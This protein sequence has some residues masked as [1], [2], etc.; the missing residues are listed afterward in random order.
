[1]L[2]SCESA[3]QTLV[4]NQDLLHMCV[5]DKILKCGSYSVSL[6]TFLAFPII[7]VESHVWR[8]LMK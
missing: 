2:L 1:M 3:L 8:A 4:G 5:V 6:C 7:F